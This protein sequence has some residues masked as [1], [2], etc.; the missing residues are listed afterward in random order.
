MIAIE[1]KQWTAAEVATLRTLWAKAAV[2]EIAAKLGR[3]VHSIIGKGRL[4]GLGPRSERRWTPA[5][6]R[7]LREAW[8]N[9]NVRVVAK[10]IGRSPLAIKNRAHVLGLRTDR[11][12][13]EEEK[14]YVRDHFATQKASDIA[15]HIHGDVRATRAIYGLAHKLGL[16]KWPSWPRSVIDKV[17]EL[18]GQGL[19]DVEI[20]EQMGLNRGQAHAIR[21]ARLVLP[22]NE[23][24][25]H[26]AQ[27][28]G[29]LKQRKTLGV[30]SA[31]ELRAL[32]FRKY[33]V[34][35]GWP[36]DCRPREVQI[37]NVLA[38]RGVPM[39]ILELA[40]AIGMRTDR[41]DA[42]H[43]R[44]LLTGNGPGGTYTASLARRG[45]VT[46]LENTARING[47]RRGSHNHYI[48]GPV[49]LQL[50]EERA[51]CQAQM[52]TA[53]GGGPSASSRRVS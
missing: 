24:G 13:T 37:L 47:Q 45:L 42:H 46:R 3:S 23:A 44:V 32:A 36:E 35:N 51:R 34:A 28:R 52:E 41:S 6:D 49:A 31:G 12:Y 4:L 9:I 22:A 7:M 19:N 43:K 38:D 1:Q 40:A 33:A 11:L 15:V 21:Y 20:G 53:T 39:T 5:Q 25:I 14:Q 29:I 18:H 48:L 16:R 2:S 27:M 10:Q 30:S 8:G 17:R 50:L 26:R